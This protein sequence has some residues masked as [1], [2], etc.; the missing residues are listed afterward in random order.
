MFKFVSVAL[1]ALMISGAA[2]PAFAKGKHDKG[3]GGGHGL[4]LGKSGGKGDKGD[5]GVEAA[6]ALFGAALGAIVAGS[7]H[8]H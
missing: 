3:G 5:K 1:V 7:K 6:A 8:R 4:S 2:A